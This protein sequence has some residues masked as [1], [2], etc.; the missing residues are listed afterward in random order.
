M[1]CWLPEASIYRTWNFEK[2]FE[3]YAKPRPRRARQSRPSR[4]AAD[5]KKRARRFQAMLDAEPGITRADLARRLGFSRAWVTKVL[6]FAAIDT[7][8]KE[9]GLLPAAGSK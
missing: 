9:I 6:G 2:V 4:V 3:G 8:L 7:G 5:R 1:M